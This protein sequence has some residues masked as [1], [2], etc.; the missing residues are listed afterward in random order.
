MLSGLTTFALGYARQA[1]ST[2]PG[3][4]P[5]GE[6]FAWLSSWLDSSTMGFVVL[7]L[8][9]FPDGRLVSRR[10]RPVVWLTALAMVLIVADPMVTPGRLYGFERVENPLGI[11]SAGFLRE[12]EVT[13]PAV[14]VL[15]PVAVIGLFVKRRRAGAEQRL[16][17]EWFLFAS[18]L[19][20][21]VLV[22]AAGA[23]VA[24]PA[25]SNTASLIGG[26]VFAAVFGFMAVSIGIAVL[27][28]RL[29]DID[30]VI[31]RALVYGALTAVL[32]GAY[33][34]SVLL[35]QLVL[36]PLTEESG[37]AVAGSTL[38][39]AALFRPARARVQALVD[40][41]FYRRRYDGVRMLEAFGARLRQEVDL[42]SLNGELRAVLDR[43]VEPAH[44]SL[45]LRE[46]EATR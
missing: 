29:Y 43:T 8:L 3:S 12:V 24:F 26:F 1:L 39:V 23:E 33:V 46:P 27:K 15:F 30:V 10:W 17:L 45:W 22:L 31:N 14:V 41:R 18:S 34:G 9:L 5:A 28:H 6:W 44:A 36:R 35:L 40:R 32:A 13:G 16:Q 20:A 38:A 11:E 7:L 21:A 25:D 42:D 19:L 4:L 2:A 37:L